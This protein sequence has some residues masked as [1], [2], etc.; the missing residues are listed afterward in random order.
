MA[1]LK[2]DGTLLSKTPGGTVLEPQ[3]EADPKVKVLVNVYE[4]TPYDHVNYPTQKHQLKFV[5]GQIISLA[6]DWNAS[7]V[8][9]TIGAI[10]PAT[11]AAAGGTTVTITGSGFTTGTTVTFGGTA[12]TS[13]SVKNDKKLTV[14]TPAKTAGAYNVVVTTAGGAATATNGFT[15]S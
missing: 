10:S 3:A 5:A 9:P 8:V 4:D 6:K 2:G 14:V 1:L 12:G 13:V 7:F 11:G 15:Y